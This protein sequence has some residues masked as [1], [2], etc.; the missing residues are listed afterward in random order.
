LHD[1]DGS[2][3]TLAGSYLAACVFLA[4]LFKENP[5]GIESEIA[6]LSAKDLSLLQKTAWQAR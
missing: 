2:H 5:V 4:A 1:K 3:P 6:G